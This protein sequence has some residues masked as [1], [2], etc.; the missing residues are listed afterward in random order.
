M[1]ILCEKPCQTEVKT[2]KLVAWLSSHLYKLLWK[3]YWRHCASCFVLGFVTLR[4]I[5]QLQS[6]SLYIHGQSAWSYKQLTFVEYLNDS[7]KFMTIIFTA[8]RQLGT[9]TSTIVT[10]SLK[11]FFINI[12]RPTQNGSHFADDIT[13]C[14][15]LNEKVWISFRILL[16]DIPKGLINDNG[17]FLRQWLWWSGNKPLAESL[18]V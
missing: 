4:R 1:K 13:K 2:S 7:L 16:T 17:A 6:I 5:I 11:C 12:L 14:I 15:L 10:I 18:M 9:F 8:K 3:L